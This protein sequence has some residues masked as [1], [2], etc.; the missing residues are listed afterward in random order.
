M[1]N[2]GGQLSHLL[3]AN[4]NL[5]FCSQKDE[6]MTYLM[7][8]WIVLGMLWFEVNLNKSEII[9]MGNVEDS[10]SLAY[11]LRCKSGKL[12]SKYQGQP[13][14]LAFKS[15]LVWDGTKEKM[16][17]K[18]SMWKRNYL[19]KGGT[20]NTNS[21]HFD[22]LTYIYNV[23]LCYTKINGK[24]LEKSQRGFLWKHTKKTSPSEKEHLL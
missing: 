18:S 10:N 16:R 20:L 8:T 21:K 5:I 23:P 11:Y 3:F 19:S 22:K 2:S 24:R 1:G 12:R 4:D 6:Q 13:L 17:R 7:W 14:G 15:K 9:P